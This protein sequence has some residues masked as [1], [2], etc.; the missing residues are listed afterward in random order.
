MSETYDPRERIRKK[1]DFADLYE[2]GGCYRG[3]YFNLIFR[4]NGLEFSRMSAV[5]SKKVGDAVRRNRA[6]RR[7]RDLFRRNRTLLTFPMDIL[8]ISKAP[9]NR[10][11]FAELLRETK[12]QILAQPTLILNGVHD[13]ITPPE[14]SDELEAGLVNA[15][16]TRVI[17]QLSSHD[18]PEDEP[19]L[20]LDAVRGFLTGCLAQGGDR[21]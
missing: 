13:P 21:S 12:N 18:L 1:K 10:A 6:R 14:C 2:R 17:G 7:A 8:V 9:A 15:A 16:V 20:F 11:A 4:P 19:E 3:K 5:A